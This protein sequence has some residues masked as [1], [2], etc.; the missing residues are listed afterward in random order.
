MPAP[1]ALAGAAPASPRSDRWLLACAI[2]L[3]VA[4]SWAYLLYEA[5]AMRHMA[6]GDMAMPDAN[7]W[8]AADLTLVFVMWAIM[9]LAMMLLSATPLLLIY[10]RTLA[11]SSANGRAAAL[12]LVLAAGYLFA[13]TVFS[14]AATLAQW[15]LHSLALMS[16]MM[17]LTAPIGGGVLLVVAGLYQWTPLKHACL[18]RCRSPFLFL[19]THWRDGAAGAFR[20]GLRHGLYCTGCCWLLMGILFVVGVM[21]LF[22]V[23]AITAFVL[24]EKTLPKGEWL[25]HAS[26]FGLILWGSW[27]LTRTA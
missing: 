27:L 19:L 16:P 26:G 23:A 9:M 10:R 24:A 25:S 8:T 6:V 14:A 7:P 18:S 22:W 21:N 17:T 15:A 13:W 20:M 5:W 2:T 4:L 3:L 11:A 1:D 12:T